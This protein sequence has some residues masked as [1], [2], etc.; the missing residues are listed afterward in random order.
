MVQLT[1]STGSFCCFD[2]CTHT[3]HGPVV[4]RPVTIPAGGVDAIV[5]CCF[6]AT[7]AVLMRCLPLFVSTNATP[8]GSRPTRATPVPEMSRTVREDSFMAVAGGGVLVEVLGELPVALGIET[9]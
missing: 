8:F 3:T 2:C 7:S 1:G 4:P 6:V 9:D 5:R